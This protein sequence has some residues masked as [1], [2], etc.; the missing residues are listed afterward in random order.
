MLLCSEAAMRMD[1]ALSVMKGTLRQRPSDTLGGATGGGASGIFSRFLGRGC[2]FASVSLQWNLGTGT[3]G[4]RHVSL[5]ERGSLFLFTLEGWSRGEVPIFDLC[6][7][8][9]AER[10][11]R[12]WPLRLCGTSRAGDQPVRQTTP[13]VTEPIFIQYPGT[14]ELRSIRAGWTKCQ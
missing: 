13:V 6:P 12:I 8:W 11:A 1:G 2:G 3:E 5:S 9:F 7:F 4:R 14:T 10:S